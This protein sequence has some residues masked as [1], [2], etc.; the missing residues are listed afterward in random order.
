VRGENSL[1][2]YEALIRPR[3]YLQLPVDVR[4]HMN[5]QWSQRTSGLGAGLYPAC[6]LDSPH[7]FGIG[8]NCIPP[9]APART[10]SLRARLS[11]TAMTSPVAKITDDLEA[12]AASFV[13]EHRLPGAA[14]GVV[15]VDDLIWSAGIG[16]ADV[17]ARRP[18]DAS[19]LY[20]IASITKTFTGTA[21]MQ[22]RDEG[23]LHLDD[24]I[25]T[26]VP[27]LRDA[28]SPFGPIE[29][30][31][32][33]RMLSHESGLT[34]EPPGTDWSTPVYEAVI[35]RNL[36]RVSEIGTR[37][38]PNAQ[39]K[40]SNLAYQVLG[41]VV[42]RVTGAPYVDRVRS[43]IL[44]PL[45]MTNTF[46]EPLPDEALPRRATGYKARWLS[47]ELDVADTSLTIWAEGGLWSSV[48]DL[49]R[50]I[51]FQ[52]SEGSPVLA[53]STLREMHAARYL[54]NEEWT[55]A[56]GITWYAM[57]KGGVTWVQHSGGIHGFDTNACFDP[58]ERVG[59]IALLN[60]SSDA[61]ELSMELGA[62]AHAAV[63][64]AAPD[65][66]APTATPGAYRSLLGLYLSVDVGEIHRLEWRDA[67]LMF[68]DPAEPTWHP[69][70]SPT[71]DPDVFTVDPGVRESGEH[72][73]FNRTS[74]GRVA[75]VFVAADTWL[76]LD[77]VT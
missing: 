23:R 77:P 46:F 76:R 15:H 21:I 4:G 19:T 34:S 56:W 62:M 22:L 38:P 17:P 14:V 47:D 43:A 72:V 49:A 25:V 13:K 48:S 36:E 18:P 57:R 10:A 41:E 11:W 59:A 16:F 42:A 32:I 2:V 53:G 69:T 68:V 3:T 27:E 31:T 65:I 45:G 66:E 30:V 58:K 24:P 50:W 55:E 51:S 67:R 29:T 39:Q 61:A 12:K 52:L 60:G 73:V 37:I 35:A 70:L 74:D 33:R 44:E 63:R 71:E 9:A 28:A 8:L 6:S 1:Q 54:G 40:Y 64:G 5:S 20:R 26:H 75:S 7:V